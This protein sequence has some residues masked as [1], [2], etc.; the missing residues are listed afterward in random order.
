MKT[1]QMSQW[2]GQ[3]L[4]AATSHHM[5]DLNQCVVS[6]VNGSPEP[7]IRPVP[8]KS[9]GSADGAG[10]KTF[11][12]KQI[13]LHS[14]FAEICYVHAG[15]GVA[16]VN[17]NKR[18]IQKGDIICL[19]PGD[20]HSNYPQPDIT[21]FNCLIA[22]SL[23]Q[24]GS[25]VFPS[26]IGEDG[27]LRLTRFI[28]LHG[29]ALL[30]AEKLY[31]ALLREFNEKPL[32]YADSLLSTVNRLL[33]CLY[34]FQQM[35]QVQNQYHQIMAPILDYLS[36]HLATVSLNELAAVA[37]FSTGYLSRLFRVTLGMTF[38]EY[39]Q[40]LRID[41]AVR[42]VT[43]TD[44][45]IEDICLAVGYSSRMHFYNTFKKYTGFTPGM[46]RK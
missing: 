27:Q 8:N 14:D 5:F 4:L 24:K 39:V 32:Y 18:M 2:A 38:T 44:R 15:R 12:L 6:P 21:V 29:D 46:L 28:R 17:G 41:Q 1:S 30:E 9:S 7:A 33:I 42:L 13:H 45:S 19:Q 20:N 26:V 31:T 37:S 36:D 16:F 35:D 23:L 22:A 40:R 3:D 10:Q 25:G 34:R 11:D 43:Q